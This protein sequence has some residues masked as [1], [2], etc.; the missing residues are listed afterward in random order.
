METE[1]NS[2]A[3]PKLCSDTRAEGIGLC[4][5]EIQAFTGQAKEAQR[6]YCSAVSLKDFEKCSDLQTEY[7]KI[8]VEKKKKETKPAELQ[9]KEARHVRYMHIAKRKNKDEGSNQSETAAKKPFKSIQDFF[10][11][12]QTNETA[13]K[14]QTAND[15]G[16]ESGDT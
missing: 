3:R 14:V 11:L 7:R 13:G 9:I 15:D 6:K 2:A 5:L 8:L 4:S 10:K 1:L 12:K 16:N